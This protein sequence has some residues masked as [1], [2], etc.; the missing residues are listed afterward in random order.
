MLPLYKVVPDAGKKLIMSN[1]V[2]VADD[3]VYVAEM[4]DKLEA[5]CIPAQDCI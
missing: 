3:G 2:E 1:A 5:I 4:D